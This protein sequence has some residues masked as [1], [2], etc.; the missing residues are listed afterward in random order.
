MSAAP[1]G[2]ENRAPAHLILTICWRQ[3]LLSLLEDVLVRRR[4]G[5]RRGLG[6]IGGPPVWTRLSI[7]GRRSRVVVA[8]SQTM[9]LTLEGLVVGRGVA[10][11]RARH[12][13]V[14]RHG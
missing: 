12:R 1:S 6:G 13:G 5:T 10:W 11:G 3:R 8:V 9:R 2:H 4:H 7:H 14:W